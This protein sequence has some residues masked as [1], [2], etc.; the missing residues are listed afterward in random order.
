MSCE[1]TVHRKGRTNIHFLQNYSFSRCNGETIIHNAHVGRSLWRCGLWRVGN[2]QIA[3]IRIIPSIYY[4]FFR[5]LLALYTCPPF[6]HRHL[7]CFAKCFFRFC[8]FRLLRKT[9][10]KKEKSASN[11]RV[12]FARAYRCILSSISWTSLYFVR[13]CV[14]FSVTIS[15]AITPR[16]NSV[17]RSSLFTACH[18][19]LPR[20]R[21]CQIEW[22]S[23]VKVFCGSSEVVCCLCA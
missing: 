6:P 1:E 7:L 16:K 4:T 22:V 18:P 13:A 12:P 10:A 8:F 17:Y 2:H 21:E 23:F 5:V 15:S 11:I 14:S 19:K 9:G 3:L 20:G